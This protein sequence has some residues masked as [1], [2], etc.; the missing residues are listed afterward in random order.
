M[1]VQGKHNYR[2]LVTLLVASWIMAMH[3]GNKVGIYLSDF[4]AAF[5]RVF[6]QYMLA[7]CRR[8]GASDCFL[9]FLSE[10]LT[11]RRASV[12]VDGVSSDPF[13]IE[14]MVFQGTHFGPPFWNTFFADVSGPAASNGAKPAQFA[15]D[16][17]TYNSYPADTALEEALSDLKRSQQAIHQ[18]GAENRV[19]FG[20][21]KEV[22]TV[23]HP[24]FAHGP[25]SK[26]LGAIFDTTLTMTSYIA[27]TMRK[28]T[29]KIKALPRTGPN[30]SMSDLVKQY[31]T[32]VLGL[33]EANIGAIYHATQSVLK[34]LGRS[35][36]I[37]L[38]DLQLDARSAFLEHNMAPLNIHRDIAMLGFVHKRMLGD[39]HGDI[40]ILLP[41]SLAPESQRCTR[42][43]SDSP[44]PLFQETFDGTHPALIRR[45]IFE[46]TRVYAI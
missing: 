38:R 41:L 39:T 40:C 19:S 28:V 33:A 16:L 37:F 23:V 1:G 35:L 26:L 36:N 5:D 8:A 29:P 2:D 7:K 11:P 18:W 17:N 46:L 43:K 15:D 3:I 32:R 22:F 44:S 45:S 30:Y 31:K 27:A 20:P 6:K 14:D 34:L 12:I 4:A 21:G 25:I 10:C 9:T 42:F 13:R 24:R